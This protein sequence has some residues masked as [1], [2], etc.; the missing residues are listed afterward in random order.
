[1][2]R[3][4]LRGT[5]EPLKSRLQAARDQ[6]RCSCCQATPP[7]ACLCLMLRHPAWLRGPRLAAAPPHVTACSCALYSSSWRARWRVRRKRCS[8]R[9]SIKVGRRVR[10]GAQAPCCAP[11]GARL[12]GRPACPAA[13]PLPAD[14]FRVQ[15]AR[16]QGHTQVILEYL[17]QVG[18][19]RSLPCQRWPSPGQQPSKGGAHPCTLSAPPLQAGGDGVESAMEGARTALQQ[20]AAWIRR[21]HVSLGGAVSLLAGACYLRSP[22]A[23][24]L[25]GAAGLTD[26]CPP[27]QTV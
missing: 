21:M 20:L 16:A 6:V 25:P 27:P 17:Q 15:L 4:K 11:R 2:L 13:P 24:A 12:A 22:A 26:L 18:G 10:S 14:R 19:L 9:R 23:G 1:M 8:G 5:G 3:I 7:P